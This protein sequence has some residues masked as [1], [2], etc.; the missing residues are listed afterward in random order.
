MLTASTG[1][2]VKGQGKMPQV[3]PRPDEANHSGIIVV[4]VDYV[5]FVVHPALL[6]GL[7]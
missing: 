6:W 4:G 5:Q 2:T 7:Q 3:V 1:F